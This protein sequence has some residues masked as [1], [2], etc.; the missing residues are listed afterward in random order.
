MATRRRTLVTTNNNLVKT[1]TTALFFK[2]AIVSIILAIFLGMSFFLRVT[3]LECYQ[4]GQECPP[5]IYDKLDHLRGK[6]LFLTDFTQTLSQFETW[7]LKKYLPGKLRIDIAGSKHNFYKL[8][9][10][11]IQPSVE[12][13]LD[14]EINDN[15][16]LLYIELENAKLKPEKI[17]LIGDTF[18]VWMNSEL[19]GIIDSN[20]VQGGVYKLKLILEN[21]SL[22]EVD[23]NIKEIDTRY[24][25][26]VLRTHYLEL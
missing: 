8:E 18:V 5:E 1:K 9:G 21:I 25:M 17:E 24:K 19:R 6:P 7:Q 26:P 10:N 2:I 15:I 22:N 4:N 11:L 3:K 16:N 23:I 14:E 20:D 13:A 12:T